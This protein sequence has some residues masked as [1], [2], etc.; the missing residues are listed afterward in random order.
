[1]ATPRTSTASSGVASITF[2]DTNDWGAGFTGSVTIANGSGDPIDGWSLTFDLASEITNIW[3][4]EIVSHTG[5]HYVVRNSSWDAAVA[6]NGSVSFG[7][8][9]DGGNPVLPGSYVLNGERIDSEG[10]TTPPGGTDA[11]PAPALPIIQPQG[12]TVH[13]AASAP[14]GSGQ[15]GAGN[16]LPAGYL[17]TKGNQIVGADGNPVRIAAVNWFGMGTSTFA[18]HGLWARNYRSMMDQMVQ[19]GFNAV[20]LSFCLQLFDPGSAPNSIDYGKNPDLQGLDGLQVMDKVVGYAGQVGLKVILDEHTSAADGP[21]GSGLWY[22]SGYTEAQW[23]AT[24]TMLAQH[25]A[26]NATVVGGDLHNEPHGAATWGD[27]SADDWAAAATRGGNAIQSVNPDWL[28]FVEGIETYQGMSTGWGGNLMGVRDHPVTLTLPDK[29]VYSPH[30]YPV[31][32]YPWPWFSAPDYPDNLPDVWSKAWG[33]VYESGIA[34]VWI[35]EFGSELRTTSDQQWLSQLVKYMDGDLAG[36]GGPLVAAGQQGVSWAY[37][38]WN[39]NSNNTGG[40]LLDDWQSVD[41]AKVAAIQPALYHVGTG[42]GSGTGID[43]AIAPDVRF[44]VALSAASGQPISVHYATADGTAHAGVDYEATSG[45]LVFAPGEMVKQVTTHLLNPAGATGQV[46]FL[47]NFSSPS[48]ATLGASSVTGTIVHDGTAGSSSEASGSS[49]SGP[50]GS[51]PSPAIPDGTVSLQV[52]SDWG[53]GI[54]AG[55][56]VTNPGDAPMHGWTVK[57]TTKDVI[58]NLWN[59][60]ILGHSGDDYLIGPASYDADIAG[61]SPAQFGFQATEAAAGASIVAQL[62]RPT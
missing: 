13:D 44:T 27:G 19:L 2:D 54:V 47:V 22:D 26:G 45:D 48:G 39:P 57:V 46:Q 32:V 1:M 12:A 28:V 11:D 14:S 37:W 33:Y 51:G 42:V 24:W 36:S 41:R 61:H 50:A 10:S 43:P 35:G 5:T 62:V 18:P 56:V 53:S 9:A 4:A 20:R 59:G 17:S 58:T 16:L 25:Y 34:P 3:G 49:G 21:N 52:I 40:I 55:V 23:V 30:D 8:Q 7:F 31:S 38:S 60:T 15:A 6:A 29:V